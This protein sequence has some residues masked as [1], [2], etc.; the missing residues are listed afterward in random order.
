MSCK[1]SDFRLVDD[2]FLVCVSCGKEVKELATDANEFEMEKNGKSRYGIISSD[3]I[4]S[5][6]KKGE[7][8]MDLSL[9][10][11][12]RTKT[13]LGSGEIDEISKAKQR[14]L[15]IERRIE[16]E[17]LQKLIDPLQYT[18]SYNVVLKIRNAASN[19]LYELM[20]DSTE[21]LDSDDESSDSESEIDETDTSN[22]KR[23]K[24][25][26]PKM[27]NRGCRKNAVYSHLIKRVILC[28]L[29]EYNEREYNERI[30]L[31]Y[32]KGLTLKEIAMKIKKYG[33]PIFRETFPDFDRNYERD[34]E[35]H[36][37]CKIRNILNDLIQNGM[38]SSVY[39]QNE[40]FLRVIDFVG[41]FIFNEEVKC[42]LQNWDF[43]TQVGVIISIL[44]L[45]TPEEIISIM[46]KYD[47]RCVLATTIHTRLRSSI[48]TEI[49]ENA[50]IN[51]PK[52]RQLFKEFGNERNKINF[53]VQLQQELIQ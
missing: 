9:P 14:R 34:L 28:Y 3:S 52:W 25:S 20:K 47:D 46:N 22:K 41:N 50:F 5:T 7:V 44:G 38:Y 15:R 35:R 49:I 16:E 27:K 45:S 43:S 53:V 32:F 48:I 36:L 26:N 4:N 12:P 19:M 21:D 11:E 51:S 17:V 10:Y 37:Q 30:L 39:T 31:P 24:R 6:N 1:H 18:H 23:K 40:R 13:S 8:I 42:K 33:I 2:C 29:P